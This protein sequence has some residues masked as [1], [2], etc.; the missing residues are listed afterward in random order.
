VHD[1][2]VAAELE[3]LDRDHDGK[4]DAAERR[5]IVEKLVNQQ[6]QASQWKAIA[7]GASVASV[8]FFCVMM[9]LMIWANEVSK[10]QHVVGGTAVDVNGNVI[11]MASADT[12]LKSDGTMLVQ[13][14]TNGNRRILQEEESI[15]RT[16]SA[17]FT[18]HALTSKVP[19]RYFIELEHFAFVLPDETPEVEVYVTVQSFERV[20]EKGALCGSVVKLLTSH[21][22]FTLDD[23]HL[24]HN[25]HGDQGL[26][27]VGSFDLDEARRLHSGYGRRLS[28]AKLQ[29][30]YNFIAKSEFECI[31]SWQG[32]EEELVPEPPKKPYSY[33]SFQEL[34]CIGKKG[35]NRC[36]DDLGTILPGVSDDGEIML[37][38]ERVLVTDDYSVEVQFLPNAP[39]QRKV[40]FTKFNKTSE[41]AYITQYQVYAY[42]PKTVLHCSQRSHENAPQMQG[43]IDGYLS[44]LGTKQ[45]IYRGKSYNARRWRIVPTGSESDL[46]D[47]ALGEGFDDETF[48]GV[49]YWDTHETKAPVRLLAPAR[50]LIDNNY[51]DFAASM[52]VG[53]V[54]N[55]TSTNLLGTDPVKASAECGDEPVNSG[56]ES[57]VRPPP[58]SDIFAPTAKKFY[59]DHYRPGFA[60][61]EEEWWPRS[62][63]RFWA[64]N[65]EK[66]IQKAEQCQAAT[67]MQAQVDRLQYLGNQDLQDLMDDLR[68]RNNET[69]NTQRARKLKEDKYPFKAFGPSHGEMKRKLGFATESCVQFEE[70]LKRL[71]GFDFAI[72][73]AITEKGELS[74]KITATK[75]P[76]QPAWSTTT[77]VTLTVEG[78]ISFDFSKNEFSGKITITLTRGICKGAGVVGWAKIWGAIS[79]KLASDGNCAAISVI[80]GV[81]LE[82]GASGPVCKCD[83]GQPSSL[84]RRELEEFHANETRTHGR[85]LTHDERMKNHRRLWNDHRR[86]ELFWD[87]VVAVVTA[88]IRYIAQASCGTLASVHGKVELTVELSDLCGGRSPDLDVSF[89]FEV[90]IA[91]VGLTFKYTF[92]PIRILRKESSGNDIFSVLMQAIFNQYNLPGCSGPSCGSGAYVA[93]YGSTFTA[94]TGSFGM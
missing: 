59:L 10:E 34:S 27:A 62:F 3:A 13:V 33:T 31:S 2:H 79:L 69:A 74:G 78:E 70:P 54:A 6:E 67:S 19:D 47:E 38:V 60:P 93:P 32:Q 65:I 50:A 58:M 94:G 24:Y 83:A 16:G 75:E 51:E 14:A 40:T 82:G 41:M 8:V 92:D 61:V 5:L 37:R 18:A 73:M 55:W 88:P 39:M 30:F 11:S 44:Y 90:G 52:T 29:G 46:E 25:D 22:N 85:V 86:R 12:K 21:G 53:E 4:I 76:R 28:Q 63:H 42:L 56:N 84:R 72:C 77:G 45:H 36:V 66:G 57:I 20:P 81:G 48:N 71:A 80:G 17:G 87:D 23:D 43:D 89:V 35:Q 68:K 91:V 49:E 64:T 7:I 26:N 9:G 1:E 15:V